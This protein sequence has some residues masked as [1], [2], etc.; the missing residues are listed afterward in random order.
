MSNNERCN[1]SVQKGILNEIFSGQ[2]K[3]W[4]TYGQIVFIYKKYIECFFL[5]MF[6]LLLCIKCQ[7]M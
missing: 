5:S 6:Y 3:L 1:K 2:I 7:V 4:L